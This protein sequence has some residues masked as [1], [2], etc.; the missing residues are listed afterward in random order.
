MVWT[1]NVYR[2]VMPI[3]CGEVVLN[4]G[5]LFYEGAAD[6]ILGVISL[7]WLRFRLP[8]RTTVGVSGPEHEVVQLCLAGSAS[9]LLVVL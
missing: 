6:G 8:H 4:S 7:W 1:G 5:C 2:C 9:L 3:T